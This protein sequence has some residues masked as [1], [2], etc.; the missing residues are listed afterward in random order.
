MSYSNSTNEKQSRSRLGSLLRPVSSAL[1]VAVAATGLAPRA[2]AKWQDL[3]GTLPGTVSKGAVIGAGVAVGAA[4][5]FLIYW[6]LHHKGQVKLAIDHSASRFTDLLPGQPTN[7]TIAIRNDTSV[8]VQINSITI[9]DHSGGAFALSSLPKFSLPLAAKESFNL[10]LT[11]SPR[12]A[13]GSA[14]LHVSASNAKSKKEET[15]K[16][17]YGAPKAEKGKLLGIIPH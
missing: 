8:P 7:K 17:S 5:G 2:S 10:P 1:I 15:F 9:E 14:F 6:K 12:E 11:I 4:V 3:S 16:V 13:G